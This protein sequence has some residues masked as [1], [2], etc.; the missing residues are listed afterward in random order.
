MTKKLIVSFPEKCIGCELCVLL[1]HK[2]AEGSLGISKSPIKVIK[3]GEKYNLDADEGRISDPDKIS[4]ICPTN[5][6]TV[7][8]K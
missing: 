8:R 2:L 1:A 3:E 7:E 4:D 5:V 6:F